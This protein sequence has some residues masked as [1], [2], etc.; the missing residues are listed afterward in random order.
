VIKDGRAKGLGATAPKGVVSAFNIPSIENSL[1]GVE[2]LSWLCIAAP[3]N[4]PPADSRS[5]QQRN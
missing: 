2:F 3:A 5:T 1:P 4:L